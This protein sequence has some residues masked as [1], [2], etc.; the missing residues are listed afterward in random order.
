MLIS[1]SITMRQNSQ[2]F[3]P[4]FKFQ[5]IVGA[6]HSIYSKAGDK[7]KQ[8]DQA[9][10]DVIPLT[11]DPSDDVKKRRSLLPWLGA[12]IGHLFSL[13]TEDQTQTLTMIYIY[14]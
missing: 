11:F 14:I 7:L 2:N 8:L 3:S 9:L 1:Y 6:F 12:G 4:L 10:Q 13:S 5:Q